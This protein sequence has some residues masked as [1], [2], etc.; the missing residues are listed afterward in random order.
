MLWETA[1]AEFVFTDT[2]WPDFGADDLRAALDAVRRPR[3][4]VRRPVS[5]FWSRI[6]VA[7]VLLPRRPR[8]RLARRL[9][10]LRRR[11]RRRPDGA[12]RALR[13]GPRPASDRARRLRRAVLT[14][15]GAEAGDIS[16]MVGGI[17][18]T[19][20]VAFVIFGF[21]DARPSATAAISLTLL[22]VVWVG[23]GLASLML[24]R[25]I[26]ENGRLVGLHRPDRGLRRRH[27]RLLR[28]PHDRPAQDG[29]EDLAG[30]VVGGV[31]RRHDRGDGGRVLRDVRPGLPHRP[32]G[33]RARRARSPSPR[34]SAISSSRRSSAT[35]A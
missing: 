3:A 2:L 27:R 31:R 24:L 17:F 32:R 9:V 29:A 16:W 6:A 12:P 20:L 21:S 30:E 10:A 15:L 23:G 33:A 13:D 22:G 5:A 35:S 4:A 7:L 19:V 1:Y 11:A 26:P 28:R 14:L 25:A 18:A 34:R 8:D